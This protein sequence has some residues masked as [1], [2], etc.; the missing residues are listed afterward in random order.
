M[1]ES[2]GIRTL[3]LSSEQFCPNEA[4]ARDKIKIGFG[5]N[6]VSRS[7]P[8]PAASS[9][10]ISYRSF[11]R[12]RENSFTPSLLLSKCEPLRWVRIWV[13]GSFLKVSNSLEVFLLQGP[14]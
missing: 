3:T 13:Y 4:G 1:A 9:E 14:E 2:G 5:R 11:P 6:G 12:M 10:R 8:S 7:N